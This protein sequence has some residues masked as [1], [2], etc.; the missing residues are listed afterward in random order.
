MLFRSGLRP[1]DIA[2]SRDGSRAYVS[3]E[4]AASISVIEVGAA[5][6]VDTLTLPEG[7]LP[8]GLALAPDDNTLYVANGRGR[9][10]VAINLLRGEIS[11][12]VEVGARPWGLTISPDD[13]KLFSANGPSD[14]VSVID[15]S[16]FTG[17]DTVNVGETPWGVWV[18]PKL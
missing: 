5:V 3:N 1:R 12:S 9:T 14:D 17:I 15:V 13:S 8:M 16:C 2:F 18:G 10:V 4:F 6:V 7:S 11:G